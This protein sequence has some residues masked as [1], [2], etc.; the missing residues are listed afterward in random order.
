MTT[1]ERVKRLEQV[2]AILM[3]AL[4]RQD[5]EK[6][7]NWGYPSFRAELRDLRFALADVDRQ[8]FAAEE[9]RKETK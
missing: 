6:D 3:D 1:E 8:S 5:T 4:D 2:V 7:G 9:S